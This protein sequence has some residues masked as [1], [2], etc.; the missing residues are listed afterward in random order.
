MNIEDPHCRERTRMVTETT[1]GDI[2]VE[3][4]AVVGAGDGD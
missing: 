2:R 1:N 4:R 3:L